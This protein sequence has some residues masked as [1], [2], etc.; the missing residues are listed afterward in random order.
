MIAMRTHIGRVNQ[1]EAEWIALLGCTRD[2]MVRDKHER[3]PAQAARLLSPDLLRGPQRVPRGLERP[4]GRTIRGGR[5]A[6]LAALERGMPL[7]DG[8]HS[9]RVVERIVV[10]RVESRKL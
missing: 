4:R 9:G 7:C 8:R 3:A 2:S 6:T 10:T 5:G 1:K